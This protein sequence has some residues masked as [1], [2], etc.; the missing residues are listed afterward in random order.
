M[1]LETLSLLGE[2]PPWAL[3]AATPRFGPNLRYPASMNHL[4]SRLLFRFTLAA[5]CSVTHAD[6]RKLLGVCGSAHRVSP[7]L[8]AHKMVTGPRKRAGRARHRGLAEDA[9]RLRRGPQ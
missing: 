3:P 7:H 5:R 2:T 9:L 8:Q 6:R 4:R 1:G